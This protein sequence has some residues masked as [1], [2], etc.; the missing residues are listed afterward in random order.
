M[1]AIYN[2]KNEISA[3][4]YSGNTGFE[5]EEETDE[6]KVLDYWDVP[7]KNQVVVT[8]YSK[9]FSENQIKVFIRGNKIMIL[10][11]EHVDSGKSA[12]VY[13]SDWQSFYP[14]SYTRIRNISFLLPGDN[15]YLLRYFQ[16]PE[17]FILKIILGRLINN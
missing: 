11:T 4:I 6:V 16:V 3:N 7:D 10:I 2:S 14:Q 17:E 8:L 12:T 13:F 5:K 9:L 15:F 1:K